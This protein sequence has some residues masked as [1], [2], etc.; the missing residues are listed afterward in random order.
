[1]LSDDCKWSALLKLRL[2]EARQQTLRASLESL[3][4][5]AKVSIRELAQELSSLKEKRTKLSIATNSSI[6][7]S[8]TRQ[9]RCRYQWRVKLGVETIPPQIPGLLESLT[10]ELTAER[11][12]LATWEHKVEIEVGY[13]QWELMYYWNHDCCGSYSPLNY[14]TSSSCNEMV[15]VLVRTCAMSRVNMIDD[16]VKLAGQWRGPCLLDA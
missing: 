8:T 1:M 13:M 16:E 6:S 14:G 11:Q 5:A 9:V 2:L 3:P 12:T 10:R 15:V 4:Q 7:A